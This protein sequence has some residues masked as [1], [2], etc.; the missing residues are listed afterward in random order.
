[1][2]ELND[3][4]RRRNMQVIYLLSGTN[5]NSGN[6]VFTAELKFVGEL[7]YLNKRLNYDRYIYM[8]LADT[9]SIKTEKEKDLLRYI[10]K[11]SNASHMNLMKKMKPGMY[12]RDME[13]LFMTYLSENYRTRFWAYNCICGS[14]PNAATLH[15]DV[16][17]RQMQD[18]DLFLTD[19]GIRFCG[20]VSDISTTFP[21]N[22][23][24]T[25][26]QKE[27]YDIVLKANRDVIASMKPGITT[28]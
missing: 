17:N 2:S 8:V 18:G 16:N 26:K 28:Y 5:E 11:I 22:G 4:I 24:F 12:E 1:M 7:A 3:F 14:G 13:N 15:Y 23:K 25:E 9:R 20:Y 10:G 21:V 27:I 19:M 6:P